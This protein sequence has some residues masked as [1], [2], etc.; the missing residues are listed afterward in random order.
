MRLPMRTDL[1]PVSPDNPIF[2]NS[3]G[4]HYGSANSL[5]LELAGIDSLTPDPVGGVIDR[6]TTGVPTGV[7]WNHPAMDLVR[8]HIPPLDENQLAQD[9]LFAQELCL[10]T[11]ITSYQDVNTRGM[12][13]VQGYYLALDSLKCRAFLL[14]TI[15]RSAD[16]DVSLEILDVYRGDW[17]SLG[18]DK[19]L[20]DGQPP[21]SYTYEPHPGPSWD[22]PTWDPDS[23]E[24]VVKQLHRAGHQMAFHCMGDHAIDLA[25]DM[26]EAAQEDTFRNDHRHRLG[27]CLIEVI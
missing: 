5:A 14:F 4:G 7:F 9:V 24:T 11:G 26:I 27:I 3:M 10:V 19:F 20:L 23:L 12:K 2:L 22:L 15:E 16:A 13:R 8:S 6:D 21:T 17:L 25:L 18:G 1:D